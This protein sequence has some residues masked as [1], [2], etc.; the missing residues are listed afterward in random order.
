[1]RKGNREE[2]R[3]RELKEQKI[4]ES[5]ERAAE[6]PKA[7]EEEAKGKALGEAPGE[8]FEEWHFNNND[9]IAYAA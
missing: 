3:R 7:R 4:Q 6:I 8:M 2:A 9:E 5:R 1:M